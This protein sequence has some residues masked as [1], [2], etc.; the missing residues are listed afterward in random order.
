MGSQ[1]KYYLDDWLNLHGFNRDRIWA[2]LSNVSTDITDE[3]NILSAPAN[4]SLKDAKSIVFSA[5]ENEM[6]FIQATELLSEINLMP[7][8]ASEEFPYTLDNGA[9]EVPSIICSYQNNARTL[10]NLAHEYAHAL[11]MILSKGK[12]MPPVYREVCAFL[13]EKALLKYTEKNL[14]GLGKSLQNIWDLD[15][16]TYKEADL[17]MLRRAFKQKDREYNYRWNYPIA[18]I[19]AEK[20]CLEQNRSLTKEMFCNTDL[21]SDI[22]RKLAL[23]SK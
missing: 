6:D 15:N 13:G 17:L 16:A 18:R 8:S 7:Q 19:V 9:E 1:R 4:L 21:E 23:F 12:F 14:Q 22:F 10:I 20:L 2:I 3:A 11:Q 5:F